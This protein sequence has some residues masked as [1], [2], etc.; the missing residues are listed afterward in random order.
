MSTQPIQT[1][2]VRS[3]DEWRTLMHQFESQGITVKA[4]C[5]QHKIVQSTFYKWKS[6]FR[7]DGAVS[8]P[9]C[10]DVPQPATQTKSTDFL[11]LGAM[12]L[13]ASRITPAECVDFL[14]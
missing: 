1:P 13:R 6:K 4:F 5:Q 14:K 10:D 11:N 9:S 8:Q 12:N 3:Y 2:R 7:K